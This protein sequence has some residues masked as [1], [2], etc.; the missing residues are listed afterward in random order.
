[1]SLFKKILKAP[2]KHHKKVLGA[3]AKLAKATTPKGSIA[4]KFAGRVAK[5]ASGGKSGGTMSQTARTAATT[6][7]ASRAAPSRGGR[8]GGGGASKSGRLRQ[9]MK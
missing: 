8:A 6:A 9:K 4:N 5:M 2:L 1:M 7:L 3:S